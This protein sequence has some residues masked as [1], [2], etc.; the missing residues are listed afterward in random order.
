MITLNTRNDFALT[1]EV[2]GNTFLFSQIKESIS[3]IKLMNLQSFHEFILDMGAF[4]STSI[5]QKH[6]ERLW[7]DVI[8]KI[9][10]R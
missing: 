8:T 6:V 2:F 5:T 9:I 10:K 4:D 1:N 3:R 7:T